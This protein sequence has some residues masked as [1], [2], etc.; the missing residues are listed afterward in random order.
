[1]PRLLTARAAARYLGVGEPTLRRW[2]QGDHIPVWRDPVTGRQRFSVLELDDWLT[3][4]GRDS[5][6]R[7][8]A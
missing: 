2:V 1:M 3:R 5:E 6:R 7:T 4:V 8:T